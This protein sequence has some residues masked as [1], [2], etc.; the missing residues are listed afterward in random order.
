[1]HGAASRRGGGFLFVCL[2]IFKLAKVMC[3]QRSNT[4]A[5]VDLCSV[6]PNKVWKSKKGLRSLASEMR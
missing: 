5:T 6:I 3:T 4:Q 1:M 2:S